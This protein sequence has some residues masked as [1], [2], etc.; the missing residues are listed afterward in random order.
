MTKTHLSREERAAQLRSMLETDQG[1]EEV[2]RLFIACY[3]PGIMPSSGSLIIETILAHEFRDRDDD[4]S[5]RD[6]TRLQKR[7][8]TFDQTLPNEGRAMP[9]ASWHPDVYVRVP[10]NANLVPVYQDEN[11][12]LWAY[13]SL[14][15]QSYQ[16]RD[17]AALEG[18]GVNK[19][20]EQ[21][22]KM[23]TGALPA[24]SVP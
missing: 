7:W 10:T 6:Q 22:I 2:H 5:R 23:K 12:K 9:T 15:Q 20:L 17:L 24:G 4:G 21:L 1:R 14:G 8:Q 3:Q 19:L 16:V 13:D 11:G 18:P